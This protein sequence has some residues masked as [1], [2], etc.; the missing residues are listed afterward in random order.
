MKLKCM[1]SKNKGPEVVGS[2]GEEKE[3]ELYH[4]SKLYET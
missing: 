2:F 3:A 1:K 4:K